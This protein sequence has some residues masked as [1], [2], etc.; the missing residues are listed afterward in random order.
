MAEIILNLHMHTRYSDGQGLHADIGRAALQSNIVDAVL[1]TDHNTYVRGV[2]RY[3][4]SGKRKILLLVGEEVHDQARNPQKNHLLVFNANRELAT[5]AYH[6]QILIDQVNASGG[7]SFL[8][9]PVEDALPDFGETAI[10]W[11]AWDAHGYTGLELWNGLSE[12]K[13]VSHSKFDLFR[14]VFF[15]ET[16]AHGPQP[17]VLEIWDSLLNEGQKVV[18]IGGSDAH[19][20]RYQYGPLSKIVFPYKFHFQC[21]NTHLMTDEALTGDMLHDK[22]M[23]YGALQ[24]G[25]CFIGYDLP[26]C[27]RGFR[28]TVQGR[29]CSGSIGDDVISS[30]SVTFQ[31][32]VPQPAFIR[33]MRNGEMAGEWAEKDLITY[34][35]SEP[36]IYRVE[37]YLHFS[38]KLRGWIFSNPIYFRKK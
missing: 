2:E 23:I 3:Y 33:L 26:A 27:T 9:H 37:V 29:D 8:A 6:P 19:A 5:Y 13:S 7:L 32:K 18:A 15:P 30:D 34:S 1:V 20:L 17:A 4:E 14:Y 35:T 31:V 12:L 24:K 10:S 25:S 38:G 36:G 21:I 11:E 16:L 22:R 28:F